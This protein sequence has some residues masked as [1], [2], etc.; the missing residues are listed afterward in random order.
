MNL[1]A[2]KRRGRPVVRA[3][4]RRDRT[5]RARVTEEEEEKFVRLGGAEWLRAAL[6]RARET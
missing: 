5:V 1:P 3:D 4:Q 6:K 2:K